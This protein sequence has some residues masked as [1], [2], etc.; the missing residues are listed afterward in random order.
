MQDESDN[1]IKK[2][3]LNEE[4]KYNINRLNV[5]NNEMFELEA[6]NTFGRFSLPVESVLKK[7]ILLNS[8]KNDSGKKKSLEGIQVCSIHNKALEAYCDTER[9]L[10]C[11]NCIL[12]KKHEAHII[13]SLEEA[14][15]KE[16]GE[17]LRIELEVKNAEQ[18]ISDQLNHIKELEE[19]LFNFK[20]IN[21]SEITSFYSKI[22]EKIKEQEKKTSESM[23]KVLEEE[24]QKMNLIKEKVNNLLINDLLQIFDEINEMK[25]SSYPKTEFLQNFK[26]ISD[27]ISSFLEILK[28]EESKVSKQKSEYS[29]FMYLKLEFKPLDETVNLTKF[30]NN[31]IIKEYKYC[32]ER[33][34]ILNKKFDVFEFD[35]LLDGTKNDNIYKFDEKYD[36]IDP[37]RLTLKGII[38]LNY[39]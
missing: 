24:I 33:D 27:R 31:E 2:K 26:K 38:Y 20:D 9:S 12:E 35:K 30:I 29:D 10:I 18:S 5:N 19:D 22:I 32:N 25:I 1:K 7:N 4:S 3:D 39:N 15:K 13:L 23:D 21:T 37:H 8:N 17:I 14:W 34:K 11:I 36:S 6:E 28:I 16:R